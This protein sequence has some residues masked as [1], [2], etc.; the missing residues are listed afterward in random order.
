M[1]SRR[2]PTI[3]SAQACSQSLFCSIPTLD[4]SAVAA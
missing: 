1:L 4:L 2:P 3:D